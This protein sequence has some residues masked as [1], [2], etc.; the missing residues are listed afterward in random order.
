MT[1]L[2]RYFG[3]RLV[4]T[5]F[6]TIAAL[7][8]VFILIDLLT[9][10][11]ADISKYDI[12]WNV[13]LQYYASMMPT[14]LCEYQVGALSLLLAALL[15]LGAAAQNNEVT[16]ALAGG[17]SLWRLVRMPVLL[18]AL[19][20]VAIFVMQET[21]GVSAAHRIDDLRSHYFSKNI[22][23]KRPG[24][25]WPR[26]AGEWTCHIM[27]FNRTALTGENVLMHSTRKDAQEQIQA[28]R[29]Y[30]EPATRQWMLEDGGWYRF[31]PEE[32]QIEV[33]RIKQC[34]APIR[35]TPEELFALEQTP[36]QKTVARLR[37][38]ITRAEALNMPVGRHYTDLY[39]KFS[40][41]FL[42]FVM[43]WLA[44]PFAIRLRRGGLA[45]GFGIS[46]AIAVLYLMVSRSAMGLGHYERISPFAAAW[47]ANIV[48]FIVGLVLFRKSS[49]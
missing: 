27:K 40:Q 19:L 47:M 28:R 30:W 15:V 46:A 21:V 39:A 42:S 26:L 3:A 43:I 48:F 32:V 4:M 31:P 35:E 36:E 41:P 8:F 17:I 6:K 14:I 2:D 45:I 33:E 10:R 38:D 37:A 22:Q 34:P 25:T 5:L 12:P 24:V 13:V 16:A 29:I 23:A 11:R 49:A 9:Q 18:A 20:A 44:I 1:T 7:L